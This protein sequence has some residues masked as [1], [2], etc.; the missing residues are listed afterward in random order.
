MFKREHSF[1]SG[2][3]EEGL[4]TIHASQRNSRN[5]LTWVRTPNQ[6]DAKGCSPTWFESG[7]ATD[8]LSD[9]G[10]LPLIT[11]QFS[12]KICMVCGRMQA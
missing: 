10:A 5:G 9:H 4:S 11:D 2:A 8:G 12:Q 7:F 3:A 1:S 6:N